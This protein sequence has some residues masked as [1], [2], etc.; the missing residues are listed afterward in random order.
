MGIVIIQIILGIFAFFLFFAGI[1]N[2]HT[3]YVI[4]VGAVSLL[5]TL[6]ISYYAGRQS[7]S[8]GIKAALGFASPALL[9]AILSVGDALSAGKFEPLMFW[10]AAGVS[11]FVAG[12]LG[13]VFARRSQHAVS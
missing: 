1:F 2:G 8:T 7:K 12:L 6:V 11:A 3:Q 9:F 13:V 4:L 5:A 10:S